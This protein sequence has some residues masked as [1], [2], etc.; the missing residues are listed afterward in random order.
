M[1]A[2]PSHLKEGQGPAGAQTHTNTHVL[3]MTT[4]L[5]SPGARSAF[6]DAHL[7][8]LMASLQRTPASLLLSQMALSAAEAASAPGTLCV[9]WTRVS[10]RS[11]TSSSGL[12]RMPALDGAATAV[13]VWCIAATAAAVGRAV[14]AT[15]AWHA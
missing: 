10:S 6:H 15:C 14:D 2:L 3:F 1:F 5:N 12:V 4:V 9:C 11:E 13:V 7:P 8:V